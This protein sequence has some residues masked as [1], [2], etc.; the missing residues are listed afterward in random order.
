[1]DKQKILL[2]NKLVWPSEPYKPNPAMMS[3]SLLFL[4]A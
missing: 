1:M 4:W 3:G 2:N